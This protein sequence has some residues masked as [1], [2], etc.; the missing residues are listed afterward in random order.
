M[1]DAQFDL[2]DIVK[3]I[4]TVAEACTGM[5][6]GDIVRPLVTHNRTTKR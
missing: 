5:P 4:K 3:K 2:F 1:S 6:S